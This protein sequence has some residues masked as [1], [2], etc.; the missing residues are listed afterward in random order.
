MQ[1]SAHVGSC[2]IDSMHKFWLKDSRSGNRNCQ[3]NSKE[4]H[5]TVHL[6]HRSGRACYISRTKR[7]ARAR[8]A[9]DSITRL[10]EDTLAA[11]LIDYGNIHLVPSLFGA[12]AIHTITICRK[13]RIHKKL[14]QNKSRQCLL[15]LGEL[16]KSWPVSFWITKAFIDLM[17]RLADHVCEDSIV[18]ISSRILTNEQYRTLTEHSYPIHQQRTTISINREQNPP[19]AY[20]RE[21]STQCDDLYHN[22]QEV[23]PLSDSFLWTSYF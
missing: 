13:D 4:G 2:Q 6:A 18:K 9:A 20:N 19:D 3:N 7:D 14:A 22:R 12:L 16:A 5:W 8:V 11:G 23:G 15:A 1:S 17:A 21:S 10:A